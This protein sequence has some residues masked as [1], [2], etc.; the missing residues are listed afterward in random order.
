M[1]GARLCVNSGGAKFAAHLNSY[2]QPPANLVVLFPETGDSLH[3]AFF[4][5]ISVPHGGTPNDKCQ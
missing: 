1:A 4:K 2:S 5:N 3:A